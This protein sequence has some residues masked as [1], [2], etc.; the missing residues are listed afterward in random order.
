MVAFI[1]FII[2]IILVCGSAF[3]LADVYITRQLHNVNILLALL[4]MTMVITSV[5]MGLVSV[6]DAVAIQKEQ[7]SKACHAAG[8]DHVEEML[9]EHDQCWNT[10]LG[11]R[12]FPTFEVT[13]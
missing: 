2:G 7:F 11:K 9:R 13:N 6:G 3:A 8:G 4:G 1:I 10:A 5:V 12:I